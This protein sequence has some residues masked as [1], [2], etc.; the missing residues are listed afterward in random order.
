MKV[1]S[2]D[3]LHLR[4]LE[5]QDSDFILELLNDRTFI[6]NIADR[7]VRT[8]ED[9]IKYI[10]KIR[11]NYLKNGLGFFLVT[12]HSQNKLGICGII[13]RENLPDPD[14]G[15]AFLPR[16]TGQGIAYESARAIMDKGVNEW[17]MNKICAIISSHNERSKRLV[18]KL[19]LSYEKI[20]EMTPGAPVELFVWEKK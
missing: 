15:F 9:A 13:Q 3:R 10:D 18:K 19:G 4:W 2:T 11:V 8:T 12:D 20:V 1:L 16:Y 5:H 14:V 7:N 17:N 6:D